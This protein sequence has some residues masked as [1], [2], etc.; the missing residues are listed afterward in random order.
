[1]ASPD[2]SDYADLA[3]YD[4]TPTQIAEASIAYARGVLPE[5]TPVTGSI[6]DA[7]L[8]ASASMTAELIAAINRMTP[9]LLEVVLQLFGIT[10]NSGT[11]ATGTL[12][13]VVSDNLGYTIPVGTRF[14]Y[15]DSS[16][17]DNPILYTFDTT[18]PLTITAGN[19][20]GTVAIAA[21]L[22]R[23]YP[24]LISGESIQLLTP[25]SFIQSAALASDLVIGSDAESDAEYFAR[26]VSKLNSFS[27]ALVLP[28]QFQQYVLSNYTEVYRCKAFSR[29]NPSA[30]LLADPLANGYVTVYAAR[31]GGGSLT[32]AAAS[33]IAED[34][35]DHAVAGLTVTVK[36]PTLVTV[37]V[38]VTVTPLPGYSSAAIT[39]GIE[40]AV[41][42]YI[43]P[44]YWPW[45]EKI[46]LNEM[47]SLID[48]VDGVDRVVTLT[49]NGSATDYSFT[50]YGTLPRASLTSAVV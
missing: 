47:I 48:Q 27:D 12:Q 5:F 11:L 8:N 16:D 14:G 21:A 26:A 46:Y 49:L 38:N 20:S 19:T 34:L 41:N 37:P 50:R 31:V 44:D 45:S 25:T 2:I 13:I 17:V 10:R 35:S 32:P 3:L 40:A 36:A 7:F 4:R 42:T 18:A 22:R 39:D 23:Q 24:A 29:V 30:D 33:A 9:G 43:H 28:D 15:L 6:E 1:M